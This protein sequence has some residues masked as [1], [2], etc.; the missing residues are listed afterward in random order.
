M[1]QQATPLTAEPSQ[2]LRQEFR[3]TLALA[4]PLAAA[5]LLQMLVHAIDVIFVARL[6]DA[7]LAASSLGVSIFGLLLWTG[8]GLVGAAAPLIAAELGRRKHAVREVRRTVRMALWLSALVSLLFM[9]ICAAGGPIMTLTGQPAET[10]A[11]AAGFLLILMW[12]MFPMI[13]ATVLRIFVSA[14]GRPTI[15]TAITFGAL[16]VN[17]LGNWTLVFGNLGMPALGLHGSAISSVITSVLMLLAYV[18]VIQSDRRLRRYHLFGNWWRTEWTRF[19]DMLRIGTPISLTILAEAGLFTGAAFLMGRIGEAELA[20]HTIALQVA[21]L[22]FQ[23][24]FGVAQ[25]ATI[26]VGLAYGARDHRGIA[27]AGQASLVLGI[28]FMA[29]TALL[30]WLFPALVLSIYVDVDAA[31]NAALVGFAMQ[32]LVVAAAFQLFDGAQ[33]VAAGVLR[34]LQDTRTPMIIAICGY[35]IAGYGTAIYLGFWTPLAGVGVWI[36]LAVGLIVVSA[37]L[38]MRWRMRARLGLLPS[39]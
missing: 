7:A 14:L 5:N 32:F 21:A 33:A 29:F 24:P 1:L 2:G 11:R 30:M 10:S 28:G 23:I 31:R 25:A 3:A 37:V 22:A 17:A 39:T 6:G 9:G 8:S 19:F 12:G 36:G 4:L 18:V 34:G 35:W 15:A 26:R 16:G 13:A 20:G 38:L 27:H